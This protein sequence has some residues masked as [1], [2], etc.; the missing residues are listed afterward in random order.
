LNQPQPSVFQR[1]I[2]VTGQ[3]VSVNL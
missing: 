3:G 2:S 1:L